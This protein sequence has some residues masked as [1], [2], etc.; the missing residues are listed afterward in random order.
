MDFNF[1]RVALL[2]FADSVMVNQGFTNEKF[3][4]EQ[5]INRWAID[6]VG[7]GNSA[8]PFE[9]SLEQLRYEEGKKLIIA[10][11][12]GVWSYQEKAIANAKECKYNGI[13]IRAIGFGSA[14]INF[15][16][17]LSTSEDGYNFTRSGEELTQALLNIATEISTNKL[18][19]N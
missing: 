14:D 10:L 18:K 6:M 12:D 3:L 15:L 16:K 5:G 1:T 8:E 13:E 2:P 9:E 11:T 7:F 4:L 17:Q 19:S